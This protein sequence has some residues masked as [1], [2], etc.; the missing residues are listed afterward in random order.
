MEVGASLENV[1]SGLASL[2]PV[3]GRLYRQTFGKVTVI[4][5]SYNANV[6][7]VKAAIN[8]L[9]ETA[10]A[11]VLILGDMAELG[12]DVTQYHEVLGKHAQQTGIDFLLTTGQYS[13][14]S[15]AAFGAGGTHCSDTDHV[16]VVANKIIAESENTITILVKGSRSAKMERVVTLLEKILMQPID[17]NGDIS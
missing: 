9:G 14:H 16:A 3:K 1:V 11:T 2:T 4:D 13:N 12:E 5:D 8:L 7:S 15:S 10:G 17:K 6:G